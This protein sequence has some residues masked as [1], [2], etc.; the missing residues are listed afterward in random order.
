M[1]GLN[2]NRALKSA[3]SG[4]KTKFLSVVPIFAIELISWPVRI[5]SLVLT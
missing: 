4:P 3:E 1:N 2:Y 5:D